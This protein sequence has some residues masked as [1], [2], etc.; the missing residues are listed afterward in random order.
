MTQQLEDE[1]ANLDEKIKTLEGKM[2]VLLPCPVSLCTHNFKYKSNK[3]RPAAPIIRPA[4]LNPKNS[5]TEN[6]KNND[7]K[8]PRKTAKNVSVEI[9]SKIQTN[10]SFAALNTA[11]KDAKE[12]ATPKTRPI[13]MKHFNEYNL[14]LQNLHKTHPTATNT[15]VGGYIKIQ[16]ESEKHHREITQMLTEKKIQ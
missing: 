3:K 9:N 13:M 8:I 11:N 16:A 10:N 7:F 5:K 1:A 4:K 12:V 6:T 14:I 2:S 15:H